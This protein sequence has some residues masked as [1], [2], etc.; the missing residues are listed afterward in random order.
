MS[1]VHRRSATSIAAFSEMEVVVDRLV[2]GGEG[3]ARYQGVPIFIPLSA[4]GDR[5]LV[6]VVERH[7]DYARAE[8]VR[9]L[10]PGPTRRAAP[11]P[12]FGLCGGCDLQH[13]ADEEQSRL[14]V[15][16]AL[17]ALRRLG[18]IHQPPEVRMIAGSSWAY[19]LRTQVRLEEDL[20]G[21]RAGYFGR[22]SHMLVP[23]S[24]CPVLVPD[25]ERELA[26]L[27]TVV[28]VGGPRRIDLAAG[29]DGTVVAA[30]PV[31]GLSRGS[32]FRDVGRYRYEYDARVFF[33]GHAGLLAD[34]V[35]EVC[36][37]W[38]GEKLVELFAGVGLL[39]LP[40]A[41]RYGQVI[42]VESDRV[43]S[44]LLKKNARSNGL[45]NVEIVARSV[46]YFVRHFGGA[47]DRVVVDPPRSG[48]HVLTRMAIV[49]SR[50][51]RLTYLSCHPASLARDLKDLLATFELESLCFLD[52][53]PQTG[54]IET[55]A[56]LVRKAG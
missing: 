36:G 23:V 28:P 51:T 29:D 56:Q 8:I 41:A 35:R 34:L 10:E 54:H 25:L 52:M 49:K 9:V 31:E 39:T 18:G 50:A 21:V 45:K 19:R 33:Q 15:E 14:K 12:V 42:A 6:N 43:A 22:G 53:F 2:A 17:E 24:E 48:L 32:V 7:T 11:C 30:P 40:L 26:E 1:E 47:A 3:L 55:L 27:P 46:D 5:V 44:R 20:E 37:P 13:I 4:P 16:A 38:R